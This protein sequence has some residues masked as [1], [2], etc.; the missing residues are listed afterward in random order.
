LSKNATASQRADAILGISTQS[1]GRQSP[2]L[3]TIQIGFCPAFAS[4]ALHENPASF[5]ATQPEIAPLIP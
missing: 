5:A 3:V 4:P 1:K 2:W